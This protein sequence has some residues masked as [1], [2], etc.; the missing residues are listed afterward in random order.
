MTRT[1]P[2]IGALDLLRGA[3]VAAMI[4]VNNPGNWNA[5]PAPLAHA[6]WNGLTVADLI[7]PAFIFIMGVAMAMA[8]EGRS[9]GRG[10][11]RAIVIRGVWLLAMGF[12]LNLAAAWPDVATIRIP[13]VL[14]RIAVTYVIAAFI[15]VHASARQM[16]GGVV[17]LLAA[18]TAL[19]ALGGSLEPGANM[20]AAIDR[21]LFGR[22]M[23]TPIGDPE[24]AL[25]LL[26]CVATAL[27]GAI[28]GQG[29]MR[30]LLQSGERSTI[31]VR[32]LLIG[33]AAVLAAGGVLALIVPLN[34]ALWTASY[35]LVTSGVTS[36]GLALCMRLMTPDVA[37]VAAPFF[38]LG[39]NPLAIYFLSEL[40]TTV[41]QRPMAWLPG[42]A[43]LKDLVYWDVVAPLIGDNG[44]ATSS[45]VY[46]LAYTALWI[47]VA[48][49]LKWRGV[50]IRV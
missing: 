26:T 30:E 8:L 36:I 13:G 12:A 16:Y 40:T 4:V 6:A 22:H 42:H 10:L 11:H 21:T 25:G 20:A 17:G 50:R 38:W 41:L 46:A 24:G 3:T 47:G 23:L 1:R 32:R 35:A 49:I 27:M 9:D 28:A 33:G 5:V 15:L 45:V 44:G 34:K 43:A 14:Q 18:H 37:R 29:I 2:R 19:L 39:T 31:A 7:F 48:G